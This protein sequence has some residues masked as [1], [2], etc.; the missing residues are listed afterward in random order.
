MAEDYYSIVGV[1]KDASEAEIKKAFRKKAMKLH[2]DQNPSETAKKEFQKLQEAYA[3]LSDSQKRSVYDQVGHQQYEQ[4]G[5]AG[6]GGGS[7]GFSGFGG[8]EGFESF[9]E[10]IFSSFGGGFGE[11]GSGRNQGKVAAT[12]VTVTL[13]EAFAGASKELDLELLVGC[14]PCNSSGSKDGKTQTCSQCRGT[15]SQNIQRGFMLLRQTCGACHGAG[16]VVKNPCG[17]CQGRGAVFGRKTLSVKIPPGIEHE[18]QLRVSGAGHAGQNGGPPGDLH[19]AVFI[20]EHDLFLRE[21]EHILCRVP[22]SIAQA[23]LGS[24]VELPTIDGG[25][26]RLSIPAGSQPDERFRLKGKGFVR[27]GSRVRG[28]LYVQIVVEIPKKLTA[29][30]KELLKEFDSNGHESAQSSFFKKVNSFFRYGDKE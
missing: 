8:G 4:M 14:Q 6:G 29:K 24:S 26:V 17:Q 25:R 16:K 10:D 27:Y 9:F 30:Q 11:R 18:T 1:A 7:H 20:K 15:G 3:V 23:A 21:G 22:V 5:S 28:D 13:E 19:V 2:P 12:Q